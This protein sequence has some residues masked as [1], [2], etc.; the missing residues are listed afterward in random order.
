MTSEAYLKPYP[1]LAAFLQVHPDVPHYSNFFLDFVDVGDNW[2]DTT[3][4][5]AG[6]ELARDVFTGCAVLVG[7]L[8]AALTLTWLVR[9]IV[10]HR[11]WLRATKVQ[12]EVH[13][14]LLE[15]LSSNEDLLAYVQSPVGS[16]FLKGLPSA[17][18]ANAMT[19][20]PLARILW[21]VQA[22]LVLASAGVGL[23]IVRSTRSM[24]PDLASLLLVMGVLVISVGVGFLL[25]GASSYILSRQLGLLE[26][27]G[28]RADA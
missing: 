18:D 19:T 14:R 25:A 15:R 17:P 10:G 20:A 27:P 8:I 16:Q 2:H 12:T 1:V 4:R 9:Y 7:F 13:G 3:P 28:R 6:I 22:G 21:S 26:A 5:Q 23:V 11:R 24:D